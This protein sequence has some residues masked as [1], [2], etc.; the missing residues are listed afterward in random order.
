MISLAWPDLAPAERRLP[1]PP[2][3]LRLESRVSAMIDRTGERAARAAVRNLLAVVASE[4]EDAPDV[5]AAPMR[6]WATLL[7][8]ID[9][10][11]RAVGL[12]M[13]PAG[14]RRARPEEID[15]A[16]AMTLPEWLDALPAAA[17]AA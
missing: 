7:L 14:Y 10:V 8:E 15:R 17:R 13:N 11:R 16:M 12:S 6:Q 2:Y 4:G 9:L 5:L 1:L 3:R